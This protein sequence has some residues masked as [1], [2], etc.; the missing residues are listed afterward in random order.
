MSTNSLRHE[1]RKFRQ[2]SDKMATALQQS[3]REMERLKAEPTV[4]AQA[5]AALKGREA[6]WAALSAA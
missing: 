3:V 5:R 4:I 6:F 1:A 2:L